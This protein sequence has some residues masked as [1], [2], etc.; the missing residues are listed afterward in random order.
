MKY[1]GRKDTKIQYAGRPVMAA[2]AVGYG[3]TH[4]EQLNQLIKDAFA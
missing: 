3:K 4:V 1:G 2:T